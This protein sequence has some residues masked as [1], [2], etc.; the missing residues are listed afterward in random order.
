MKTYRPT[1]GQQRSSTA[2]H[3]STSNVHT[4]CLWA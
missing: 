1:M 2:K 3:Y 4:L